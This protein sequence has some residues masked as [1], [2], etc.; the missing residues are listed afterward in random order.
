MTSPMTPLELLTLADDTGK[1]LADETLT[2]RRI[3]TPPR[4]A[5]RLECRF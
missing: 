3:R 1:A 4:G 5:L 2:T